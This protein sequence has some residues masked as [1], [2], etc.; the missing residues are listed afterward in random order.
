MAPT[1]LRLLL[2]VASLSPSSVAALRNQS[3]IDILPRELAL[4]QERPPDCPPC[5]NCNL[6]EFPCL[7]YGN[8]SSTSGKC[9]CPPGFGGLDCSAPLCGSLVSEDRNPRAD[10][11]DRCDCD[12]GWEGINCNVCKR[13]SV[14]DAL[15]PE[16]KG[17]VCYQGGVL[18]KENFL[19]CDVTNKKIKD[20][21]DPRIPEVTI[22]CNAQRKACN[23]QCVYATIRERLQSSLTVSSLD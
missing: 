2:C 22:S 3:S 16:S 18:Q 15:M 20:M 8:C 19:M 11:Q 9:S 7:Q 21:L 17:G 1:W 13:D 6:D 5:F 14:C 10:D 12:E 4:R 23:F